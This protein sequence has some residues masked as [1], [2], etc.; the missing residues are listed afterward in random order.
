MED[1]P[2]T[3]KSDQIEKIIAKDLAIVELATEILQ[4]R[5]QLADEGEN[6]MSTRDVIA[7]ADVSAKRYTIFK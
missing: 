7:S 5:L 6:K 3:T 4:R 2:K 1:L